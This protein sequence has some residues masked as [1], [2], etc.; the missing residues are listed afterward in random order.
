[1]TNR[2]M[3]E[4]NLIGGEWVQARFRARRS[5]S[6]ILRPGL[7]IGTVP[8][9]GTTETRRAIE[10]AQEAFMTWRK[11]SALDR[12]KLLRKLHDAIMDNQ[13][14]LAELLTMEQGKPLAESKGEIGIVGRL[15]VV[16][17]RGS[18]PHLW[19]RR[20]VALGRPAHPGDQGAG[21][22]HRR[23]HALE[24]PVLDAVPQARAGARRRLHHCG[25]AGLADAVFGPCLGSALR[26]SRLPEGRGQHPDWLGRRDRRRAQ[27]QSAGQ[28]DHLHRL[29]RSRQDADGR[30]RRRP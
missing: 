28:E 6:S 21:R 16:V 7:K 10:A 4:E 19:R 12:S 23:D 15:C 29:D 3:R 30:S 17:R 27:R 9:S 5:T 24:F 2:F 20:A 22:R 26:G 11:T 13:D 18:P 1:M 25:E 14:A 8:N